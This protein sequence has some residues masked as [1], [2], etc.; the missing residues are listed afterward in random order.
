MAGRLILFG[1]LWLVAIAIITYGA[2]L[3]FNDGQHLKHKQ[4]MYEKKN[5]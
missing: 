4:E 2:F 3:Y 5:G 1:L